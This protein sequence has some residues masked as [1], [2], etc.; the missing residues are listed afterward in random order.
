MRINFNTCTINPV[1]Q[2]FKG[3]NGASIYVDGFKAGYRKATNSTVPVYYPN[4]DATW[5]RTLYV[6][7]FKKGQDEG[8]KDVKNN[9]IRYKSIYDTSDSIPCRDMAYYNYNYKEVIPSCTECPAYY[10]DTCTNDYHIE[11]DIDEEIVEV[12]KKYDLCI[13]DAEIYKDITHN[14]ED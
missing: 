13:G 7:A 5:E 14:D 11:E 12:A 1:K 3:G 4:Y 2:S 8:T 9:E 6:S 10:N